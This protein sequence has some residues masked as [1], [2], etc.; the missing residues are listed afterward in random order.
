ML[1]RFPRRAD[2]RLFLALAAAGVVLGVVAIGGSLSAIGRVFPG[3]VVWDDLVV[4]ALGR[5]GWTGMRADVPFRTRVA[6]VDDVPVANRSELSGLVS[7]APA[8]TPHRYAFDDGEHVVERTVAS[9]RFRPSDW[10]ATMGVYVLNGTAFLLTGLAVFW[11]KPES[12]Q[13]RA[14]LAFGWVWGLTLL[15]AVDLFTAG[16]LQDLYFLFEAAAPAAALHVALRFPEGERGG[17]LIAGAYAIAVVV[18]L[19]QAWAFHHSYRLLIAVNDAVYLALALAGVLSMAH[20]ARAAFGRQATPLARRR[21]RVVLAG[22]IVAFGLPLPAMLAFFVLGEPVSFSLL[23]LAGFVFPLSI[24]YAVAR[25]DL[26]E[27]D[28]FVRQSLVWATVTALVALAYGATV[29]IADRVA[30]ELAIRQSPLFPI[31]FV[32]AVLAVVVPL[33]D[34]VQRGV[35]RLFQRGRVDYKDTIA[36]ASERMTTLL[37]RDAI[38]AHVLATSRDVLFLEGVTVWELSRDGLVR[39]DDG[40]GAR[41]VPADDPGLAALTTLDRPV[42]ADEIAESP[43]LRDRREALARLLD[44]MAATL[45]VPLLREG[46]PAGWLGV[47]GKASGGAISADDLDVLRTVANQT[48]VALGT[49]GTV[50]QL[51][52]ARKGL[53]N[54]E[55]LAAIG[56]LSAAVAHGIRNPLA[57]IRLATQLGLESAAPDDPVR[58]NLEDV[59]AE[60][61]KLETQVRGILDFAR[62]FEPRLEPVPLD[63]LV[64]GLLATL[65]P[66]LDAGRITADVRVAADL[67][68]VLADRAHLGQALQELAGNA[69]EAMPDGG[70]LSIEGAALGRDGRRTVR[71]VVGDTGPGIRPEVRDRVFQLFMTTKARGTGVGLA[72][73]RK[74]VER[75]GGTVRLG[76]GPGARFEI[77]LP[78]A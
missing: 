9:M 59:L 36:R 28:R 3:F 56:E 21:A 15:L 53:A 13:S 22:A 64:R 40:P 4:V 43:R 62:P 31:A 75:H 69:I 49:A 70:T 27:A 18:G 12:K 76:D 71:I 35:D 1:H 8:G 11:L 19:V 65:G 32:V 37:D 29:L 17:R 73:V 68:P 61:D 72:V 25:H 30:A 16:R 5:P 74:I 24:G 77:E 6:G 52:E 10:L 45:V 34:R 23:T 46:R 47:A 57:G 51:A 14:V 67:P 39:R 38:V 54:A 42:S 20:I 48:A 58:E 33:R 44:A 7:T 50:E 78:A 55:R 66:R 41:H 60:V 63:D 2:A 26:F